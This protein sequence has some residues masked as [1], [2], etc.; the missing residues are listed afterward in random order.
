MCGPIF[1]GFPIFQKPARKAL[2]T[3]YYKIDDLRHVLVVGWIIPHLNCFR[4]SMVP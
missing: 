2:E 4:G 3:Q 1:L